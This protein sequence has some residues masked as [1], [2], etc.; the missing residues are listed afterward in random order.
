MLTTSASRTDAPASLES[1]QLAPF[2]RNSGWPRAGHDQPRQLD[3]YRRMAVIAIEPTPGRRLPHKATGFRRPWPPF[4]LRPPDVLLR[5]RRRAP[6]GNAK[7]LR[8]TV[9]HVLPTPPARPAAFSPA[10][11]RPHCRRPKPG[12]REASDFEPALAAFRAEKCVSQYDQLIEVRVSFERI[13]RGINRG[14]SAV[15]GS[16]LLRPR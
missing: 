16:A 5:P 7:P 3:R 8:A 6:P 11:A 2:V 4:S 12:V 10:A 9:G 13:D 14:T 1:D 15:A